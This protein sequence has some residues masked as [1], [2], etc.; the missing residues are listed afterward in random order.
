MTSEAKCSWRKGVFVAGIS[1]QMLLEQW[2]WKEALCTSC[3]WWRV[4]GLEQPLLGSTLHEWSIPVCAGSTG[5]NST[6]SPWFYEPVLLAQPR[7]SPQP[8][9]LSAVKC[10]PIFALPPRLFA[11][12][13]PFL[14]WDAKWAPEVTLMAV[15]GGN[16]RGHLWAGISHRYR[17]GW[18]NIAQNRVFEGGE[19]EELYTH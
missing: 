18:W 4:A 13:F 12:L 17:G 15:R 11:C 5:E 14:Q 8:L 3:W 2:I 1:L 7:S 19:D 6:F 10:L 9:L 16:H